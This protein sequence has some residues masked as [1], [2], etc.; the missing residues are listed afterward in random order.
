MDLNSP[1]VTSW[2]NH[3]LH[4]A[5]GDIPSSKFYTV[6]RTQPSGESTSVVVKNVTPVAQ[7]VAMAKESIVQES[8]VIRRPK[9]SKKSIPGVKQRSLHTALKGA[10][11]QL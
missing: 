7:Q 3:F 2:E 4:Q 10:K 1:N 8:S 6:F 11:L 9:S 5:K